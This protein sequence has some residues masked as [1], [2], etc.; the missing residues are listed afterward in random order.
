MFVICLNIHCYH[1][2]ALILIAQFNFGK[3][4]NEFCIEGVGH[5]FDVL[6]HFVGL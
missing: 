6:K 5:N 3:F 1:V 2:R 4:G